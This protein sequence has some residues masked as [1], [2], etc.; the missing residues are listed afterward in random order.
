MTSSLH[1]VVWLTSA[2]A[3]LAASLALPAAAQE[4]LKLSVYPYLSSTELVSRFLPFTKYLSR[5][6]GRQV[7]L[8]IATNYD[9]HIDRIGSGG[10]DMAF[11][12]AASYVKFTA[13][14]GPRPILAAFATKEGKFYHGHVMVRMDSPI[15]SLAELKGKKFVFGD[16]VSTMSHYVPRHMLLKAGIDVKDLSQVSFLPNQENIALG[17]LT[18]TFDAGAVKEEIFKEY[19]PRG[20]RSLARSAPITDHL[21]IANTTIPDGTVRALRD[22]CLALSSSEEGRQIITGLRKDVTG[23]VPGD[24]S[25]F[26]ALRTIVKDLKEAGVEL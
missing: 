25:D 26:D 2:L 12:G 6:T 10:V 23:L 19:E 17:V 8:E 4:P 22:A 5:Q 21:F 18:G 13:G 3:F 9:T 1:R 11:M 24:D 15:T 20:L 14:Y 7:H 16:P